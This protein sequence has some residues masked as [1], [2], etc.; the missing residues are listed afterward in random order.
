MAVNIIIEDKRMIP[1]KYKVEDF[2]YEGMGYGV[3]DDAFRLVEGKT[4]DVTIVYSKENLERGIE[5]SIEKKKV[6][7]RMS[8]PTGEKEI[9]FFYEYA[10][11]ICDVFHTTIFKRE[12]EFSDI[13]QITTY[14]EYDRNASKRALVEMKENLD[15]GTYTSISLYGV[16][17]P[18]AIDKKDLEEIAEDVQKFGTFLEEK[19]KI[20]AYYGCANIY[21]KPD[22][23]IFGV[24]T[25]TE[26]VLS[27]FPLETSL[28]VN[29]KKTENVYMAFVFEQKMQGIIRYQDFL[30]SLSNI[31]KNNFYDCGH[32]L[33]RM[34]K[35]T[36]EKLLET[37]KTEM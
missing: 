23:T 2:I 16:Y 26:D 5:L 10:K 11:K 25:I 31:D 27:I 18:I 15:N 24:Y 12:E 17:N 14:M 19:Q 8:L 4:G 33:I 29:D 6:H 3:A 9:A 34:E 30:S 35:E 1:K 37:Y 32:V 28:I 20:D 21:Q 22:K 13:S 7:L 36:M